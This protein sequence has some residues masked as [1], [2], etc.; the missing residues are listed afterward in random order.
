MTAPQVLWFET[1]SRGDGAKV[2][3]KNA[4]LGEMVQALAGRGVRVPPGFATTAD[5]YWRYVDANGSEGSRHRRCST[6]SQRAA[7]HSPRPDRRS[8]RRS[9]AA[10]G[11]PKPRR[12]SRRPIASSAIA[13]ARPTSTWPS[14]RARRPRT[15]RTRASPASRRRSSTFAARRRCSTPAG[16]ATPRSSPTAR[17][18]IARSRASTT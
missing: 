3:G 16:A 7:P 8:A 6:T 5:A 13:P 10:S 9:S 11:R 18:P 2:G 12:P 15:C 14:A 1:L 4:S 17:S